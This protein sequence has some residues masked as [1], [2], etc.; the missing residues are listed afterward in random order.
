MTIQR[1]RNYIANV[2]GPARGIDPGS[3]HSHVSGARK[4]RGGRPGTYHP[5]MP[6][7]LIDALTIQFFGDPIHATGAPQRRSLALVSSCSLSA[8]NL[9]NGEFGSG[10][11]PLRS[12]VEVQVRGSRLPPSRSWRSRPRPGRSPR[13]SARPPRSGRPSRSGGRARGRLCFSLR[14]PSGSSPWR[15]LLLAGRACTGAAEE[16]ADAVAGVACIS[17]AGR[18]SDCGAD[19]SRR[20]GGRLF[21]SRLLSSRLRRGPSG[22]PGRQTSI[23]SGSTAAGVTAATTGASV[24]ELP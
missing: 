19:R 11:F 22:R 9:A 18:F 21:S 15:G 5:R 2:H 16:G 13:P 7:P 23:I 4:A 17:P 1:D 20:R 24:R 3:I 10:P 14:S 12:S 6:Q 8:S